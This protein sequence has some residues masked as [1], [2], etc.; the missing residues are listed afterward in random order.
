MTE[1]PP[2]VPSQPE[3]EMAI[4]SCVV[5]EPALLT[6]C[7]GRVQEDWFYVPTHRAIWQSFMAAHA[8]GMNPDALTTIGWAA[9]HP[10]E[11]IRKK[12]KEIERDCEKL[13]GFAPGTAAFTK[14]LDQAEDAVRRRQILRLARALTGAA[15]DPA[16]PW[17][18][19]L[20]N[21]EAHLLS[22]RTN[23]STKGTRPIV[24]VLREV[25]DK[26]ELRYQNRGKVAS[27]LSSGIPDLDRM[28]NGFQPGELWTIAARPAMGKTSAAWTLAEGFSIDT[29]KPIPGAF[30]SLEMYDREIIERALLGRADID[31]AKGRTGHF[32]TSDFNAIAREVKAMAGSPLYMFDAFGITNGDLAARIRSDTQRFGIQY[33][34]IDYGQLLR[35]TTKRAEKEKRL[36]VHETW[37]TLKGVAKRCNINIFVLAQCGRGADDTP[38]RPPLLKDLQESSAIEQFSDG[39]MFIHRTAYYIPWQKLK[40]DS[41]D[42]WEES[43]KDWEAANSRSFPDIGTHP[44]ATKGQRMYESHAQF[45]LA[46][47]RNGPVGPIDLIWHAARTRFTGRTTKLYSNNEAHRQHTEPTIA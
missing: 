34:L 44:D 24:E 17:K 20:D 43:A 25:T 47:Q 22:L 46:K 5:Q 18:E 45:I 29:D 9:A 19:A 41:Q 30:Y 6:D 37:E 32:K 8:E 15:M 40:E 38:S 39:I 35:A 4:L 26:L 13:L 23:H 2:T 11:A 10:D 3:A 27:G 16:R 36:E 33:A 31:I 42:R 12:K 28:V 21:A 14:Y 1:S 7:I